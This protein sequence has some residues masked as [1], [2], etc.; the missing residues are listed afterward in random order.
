MFSLL[1]L[2]KIFAASIIN[3]KT[4]NEKL[5]VNCEMKNYTDNHH[6]VHNYYR[7]LS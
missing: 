6:D 4:D 5:C 2:K 3:N 7:P 1:S